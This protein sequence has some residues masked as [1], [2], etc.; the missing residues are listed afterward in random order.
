MKDLTIVLD[1][2]PG[3]L[4]DMGEALGSLAR[5][6]AEAGVNIEV[7]YSDHVNQGHRRALAG[8]RPGTTGLAPP[9]TLNWCGGWPTWRKLCDGRWPPRTKRARSWG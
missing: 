3:A 1:D 6:M 4:A 7:L 5:R 2:S 8:R 9:P